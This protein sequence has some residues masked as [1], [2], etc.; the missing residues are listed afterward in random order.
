MVGESRR[1]RCL[2]GLALSSIGSG[3]TL[4]TPSE[5]S[6]DVVVAEGGISGVLGAFQPR[7][8]AS[9]P[10]NCLPNEVAA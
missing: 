4:L 10:Q 7:I 1:S 3:D 9:L 2:S 5:P 6:C 8:L